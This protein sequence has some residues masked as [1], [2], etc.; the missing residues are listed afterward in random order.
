MASQRILLLTFGGAL[1]DAVWQQVCH[2]SDARQNDKLDEWSSDDWPV[3]V[4]REIDAFIE[5]LEATCYTPPIL[6]RSEHVDCWSMGDVYETA[7]VKGHPDSTRRLYTG[8]HQIIATWVR[9]SERIIPD[10]DSPAETEWLYAR[11]NEAIGAWAQF[12]ENRLVLLVRSVLGGLW[13]DDEVIDALG[14]IPPWWNET[15]LS[16]AR[17][18]S[19]PSVLKSQSTPRSP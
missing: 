16:D 5:K 4:R 2:W 11:I 10:R 8:N 9:F 14:T 15:E 17:E 6:Y 19:A 13:T 12:A 1:A 18:T 3:S 7:L